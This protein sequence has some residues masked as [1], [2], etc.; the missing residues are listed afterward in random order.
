MID[1]SRYLER[2]T[3][4]NGLE[5]CIRAAR[6]DDCE[7][8]IEA[9]NELDPE[10]VY[11][12]FFGPKK[13]FSAAELKNFREADFV[14]RVILLGTVRRDGRELVIASATYVRVRET[15]AEVAF[16]VEEDYHRLGIARRLLHHLGRIAGAGGI[17]TF[18][19]EV[20]PYNTGMLGV[21]ERSGWPMTVEKTDGTV[22]ATLAL[23]NK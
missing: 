12:R 16:V 20:P 8:V 2:E 15:A 21:F 9:F 18:V 3:L 22:H 19:A 23:N 5:V 17:R 11:L 1:A 10:S 13:G 6:S 14:D 7:R 4:K